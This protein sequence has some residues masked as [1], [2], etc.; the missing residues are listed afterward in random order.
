MK[1]HDIVI[2]LMT[3]FLVKRLEVKKIVAH[4]AVITVIVLIKND[5]S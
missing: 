5:I 1:N 4:S 2:F 3:F